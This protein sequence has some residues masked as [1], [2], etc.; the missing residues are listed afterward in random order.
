MAFLLRAGL[1]ASVVPPLL[2]A[3]PLPVVVRAVDRVGPRLA[4]LPSPERMVQLTDG[5]LR[6]DRGPLR[7]NCTVRSLVLLRYLRRAGAPVVV[8]FGARRREPEL[9]GHAWLERDGRPWCEPTDPRETYRVMY[10]YPPEETSVARRPLSARLFHASHRVVRA[11]YGQGQRALELGKALH[12]GVW[13]GAL[14]PEALVA[15]DELAYERIYAYHTTDAHNLR[16]LFD[17]EQAAVARFFPPRGRILVTSAGGGR[18]VIA[19]RR[20]GYEVDGFECND[21]LRASGNALLARLGL[22]ADL[23]PAPRDGFPPTD[24]TWDAVVVGWGSLTYVRGRE[25]RAAFLRA[26]RARLPVGAPALLSFYARTRDS[27][28]LRVAAGAANAVGRVLGHEPVE[29]GDVLDPTFQH[30]FEEGE[31]RGA[32]AEAGFAVEHYATAPFAHVV[33]RA[34]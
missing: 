33:A 21:A 31:L 32:L 22:P 28:R 6:V 12:T 4:P 34:V 24:R 25:R 5:L 17:W 2:G 3:L 13:L 27:A 23:G 19:L 26:L 20:L 29:L 10:T 18:E 9:D 8:R 16:G 1:V 15:A 30:Y 14:S 11:A 7:A